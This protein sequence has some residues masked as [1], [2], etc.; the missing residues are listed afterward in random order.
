[1]VLVSACGG[2]GSPQTNAVEPPTVATACA[3]SD[4]F[5]AGGDYLASPEAAT[6]SSTGGTSLPAQVYDYGLRVPHWISS[7]KAPQWLMLDLGS[8]RVLTERRLC[9]IQA[10]SGMTSHRISAG[11]TTDALTPFAQVD[12]ITESGQ[13]LSIPVP[14]SI[15][16][17]VRYLKIETVAS[18]VTVAWGRIEVWGS[19]THRP[20]YFGY[21]GDAFTWLSNAT[22]EVS[23]HVN[24]SWVSSDLAGLS[25]LLA[26]LEQARTLGVRAALAV[27]VDVFFTPDL[28]LTPDYQ[29]RWNEFA[30]QIR[31]FIDDVAFLYPID[32]PYSQAKTLGIPAADMMARL[33]TIGTLMKATFP[34]VPLAFSFSA[35]DFDTQ[36]SAFADIAN[37]LPSQY[38]FFG[39]DCYGAWEACGEASFRSVHSIPWYVSRLK[40]RM[41]SDQ[42]LFLFADAFVVE[43]IPPDP[44]LDAEQARLRTWRAEQYRQLALSDTAIIGLFAFL[45]QDDYVEADQ[46]FLGVRHWP[47][48]QGRYRSLGHFITGK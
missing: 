38:D 44:A 28:E 39:F 13:L 43:S 20:T 14:G 16:S 8:P 35:I 34:S 46:R 31:P 6:A 17:L 30:D 5:P 10:Q 45:Y 41:R 42:S 29:D 15:G 26:N 21:Y 4:A 18:P 27:P 9:V 23:D 40:E 47:D 2:G 11:L 36:D 19:A 7:G 25:G 24:V 32:E 3:P 48:L 37:P 33:Q 22:L 12:G 1:M